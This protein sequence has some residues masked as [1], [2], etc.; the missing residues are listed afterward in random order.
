M[1]V[2][3]TTKTQNKKSQLNKMNQNKNKNNKYSQYNNINTNVLIIDHVK[4]VF[5]IGDMVHSSCS[6]SDR[7]VYVPP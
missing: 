7:A 1:Y 4:I 3:F 5:R 6:P 2:P